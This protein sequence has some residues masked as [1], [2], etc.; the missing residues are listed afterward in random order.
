MSTELSSQICDE[1]LKNEREEV[2]TAS[3]IDQYY[4]QIGLAIVFV[5]WILSVL[6]QVEMIASVGL[7]IFFAFIFIT[8]IERV[9]RFKSIENVASVALGLVAIIIYTTQ[10]F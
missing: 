3:F 2:Y 8:S 4:R 6:I 5:T 7:L 10:L 9:R 1:Q